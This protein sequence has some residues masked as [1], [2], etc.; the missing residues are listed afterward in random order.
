MAQKTIIIDFC[1][2]FTYYVYIFWMNVPMPG[3][4]LVEIA[5]NFTETR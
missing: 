4:L 5:T 3:L 1:I 2:I